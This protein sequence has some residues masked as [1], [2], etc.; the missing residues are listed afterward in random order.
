MFT[1][2][3]T[4][5]FGVNME[6]YREIYSLGYFLWYL[7][8][9]TVWRNLGLSGKRICLPVQEKRVQSLGREDPLEEEMTTHFS[10]L[11]WRIPWTE[12]PGGLPVMGSQIVRHD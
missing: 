4:S 11:V 3:R 9:L 1:G 2:C 12:E 7:V 6:T 8:A 5:K 10:I